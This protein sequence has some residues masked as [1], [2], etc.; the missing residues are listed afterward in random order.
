MKKIIL[1]IVAILAFSCKKEAVNIPEIVK[2]IKN[3][4]FKIIEG[5]FL[6][7]ADAAIL[8]TK[9]QVYGVIIDVKMH[10]LANKVSPLKKEHTDMVQVIIKGKI[11]PKNT[12]KEGWPFNII[13]KEIIEIKQVVIDDNIVIKK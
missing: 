8:K 5:E 10:E 6:Y 3:K 11:V 9:K 13:I 1:I 12:E 2:T 7:Y 4:E